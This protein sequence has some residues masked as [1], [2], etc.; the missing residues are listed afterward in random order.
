MSLSNVWLLG[1]KYMYIF[2]GFEESSQKVIVTKKCKVYVT[3]FDLYIYLFAG[4]H[5]VVQL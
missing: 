4:M 1:L 3:N 5:L 2:L